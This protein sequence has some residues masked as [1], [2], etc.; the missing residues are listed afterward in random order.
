M[1]AFN[2][3]TPSPP[4]RSPSEGL[5]DLLRARTRVLHAQAERSGILADILRGQAGRGG[6]ALLLRNLL[7]AYRALEA[8]LARHRDTP[9]VGGLLAPGLARA[10][11]IESDLA[12]LAGPEWPERLVLLEPGRRYGERV[13]AAAEGGGARLVA[14][15]Y[16]RYLGDLNGGQLVRRLL[17]E[18]LGLDERVLAFYAFPAIPD[19]PAFRAAYRRAVDLAVVGERELVV[20]EA[21]AAFRLNI[22]LSEA[23]REAAAEPPEVP[24]ASL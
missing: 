9:G 15:A 10:P 4:E 14:H 22:E 21:L 12:A 7:P 23:V 20:E 1:T 3:S 19:L 18:S 16:V 11:A 2:P 17:A 5:A 6:Y 13:A 8:G 24:Q